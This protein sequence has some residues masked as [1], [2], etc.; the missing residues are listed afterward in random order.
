[1]GNRVSKTVL[2]GDRPRVVERLSIAQMQEVCS[3]AAQRRMETL[4][5]SGRRA[6]LTSRE[7]VE[8]ARDAVLSADLLTTMGRECCTLSGMLD[9][10]ATAFGAGSDA[11]EFFT[12]NT[13]PEGMSLALWLV[14]MDAEGNDDTG[15]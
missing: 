14:G 2:I 1:M 9:I 11:T 7:V 4:V 15:R 5:A 10:I 8:V 12:H 6:G 13:P 3:R